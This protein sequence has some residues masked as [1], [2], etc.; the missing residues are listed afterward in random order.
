MSDERG[1]LTAFVAV[2]SVGLFVLAGLVVDGGRAV[3]AKRQ[4]IDVAQQAAR[5]GADQLSVDALRSG[6]IVIDPA[7]AS[8]A[9]E[10]YLSVADEQGTVSVR[11]TTVTVRI[12]GSAPTTILGIV[13]ISRIGVSASAS[14]TNVHGVTEQDT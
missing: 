9:V 6:S 3:V 4:A 14:A 7:A 11:G 10:R 1:S 5:V 12:V 2:L 8:A 13:G